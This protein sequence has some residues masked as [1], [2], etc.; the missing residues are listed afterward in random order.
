MCNLNNK[1][2]PFVILGTLFVVGLFALIGQRFTIDGLIVGDDVPTF[3]PAEAEVGRPR[4]DSSGFYLS[5][6]PN[7]R[8][9]DRFVIQP[10]M[11]APAALGGAMPPPSPRSE[12]EA[13]MINSLVPAPVGEQVK[14]QK[15]K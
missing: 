15:G 12:N 14:R 9:P 4:A 7:S 13:K 1:T 3:L 2:L 6:D 5:P 11:P 8:V 10:R